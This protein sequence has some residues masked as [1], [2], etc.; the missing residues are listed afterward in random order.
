[1]YYRIIHA[2]W[3]STPLILNALCVL[4]VM[5]PTRKTSDN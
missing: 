1:M 4:I 5:K 2:A 3:L